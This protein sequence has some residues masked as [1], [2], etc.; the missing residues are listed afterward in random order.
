MR[1]QA[2]SLMWTS[3]SRSPNFTNTP[4]STTP[5][6]AP[7]MT[8]PCFNLGSVGF[9]ASARREDQF[10]PTLEKLIKGQFQTTKRMMIKVEVERNGKKVFFAQAFNEITIQNLLGMV[11][12]EVMINEHPFQYVRGS[13]VLVSTATG[14]TAY[15]LSAHGPVVMPDIKCL[16]ITELLDHNTPTPSLVV[17][18]N[19]KIE[20]KV[21]NFREQGL[22][23]LASSQELVDVL[24]TADAETIF[25]LKKGDIVK[26]ERSKILVKYAEFEQ[27]YFLKSLTEKFGYR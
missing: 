17:K 26:I 14:S 18:R 16:I 19:K 20:I 12:L 11:E 10:L 2:S 6:T 1:C 23:S 21:L 24:L 4:K 15:N 25:P 8:S 13:G 27:N 22:L 7:R 5:V 3:P 9:L